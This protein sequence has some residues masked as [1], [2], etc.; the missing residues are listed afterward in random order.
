MCVNFLIVCTIGSVSQ[1]GYYWNCSE[2]IVCDNLIYDRN[3][4]EV[5]RTYVTI[6]LEEK[7]KVVSPVVRLLRMKIE[8]SIVI[9]FV[10]SLKTVEI[11]E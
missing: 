5:R 7:S 9:E 1:S 8:K 11:D 3:K 2:C 4:S 10:S 6:L